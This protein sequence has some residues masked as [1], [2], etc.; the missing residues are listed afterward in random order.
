VECERAEGEGGCTQEGPRFGAGWDG[1]V[2][3]LTDTA[4][5]GMATAAAGAGVEG[6]SDIMVA[7]AAVAVVSG[8]A[9]GR[10]MALAIAA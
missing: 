3:A 10:D 4:L 6:A 5:L 9:A 2:A 7:E 8:I 1:A